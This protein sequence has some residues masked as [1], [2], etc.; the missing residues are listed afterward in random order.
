MRR[1]LF[2]GSSTLVRY[3]KFK[4]PYKSEGY[5]FLGSSTFIRSL[6]F[7]GHDK[8]EVYIFFGIFHLCDIPQI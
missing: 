1:I 3:L 6:T 8:S 4:G 7:K 5:P 2:V